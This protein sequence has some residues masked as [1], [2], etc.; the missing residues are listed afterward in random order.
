MVTGVR[1]EKNFTFSYHHH[2]HHHHR[3]RHKSETKRQG[4]SYKLTIIIIMCTVKFSACRLSLGSYD[5]RW[6]WVY[7]WRLVDAAAGS[8]LRSILIR[9]YA[10]RLESSSLMCVAKRSYHW[11]CATLAF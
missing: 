6:R 3:P 9:F 5:R 10:S 11:R 1:F 8:C 2:H 7:S 4:R